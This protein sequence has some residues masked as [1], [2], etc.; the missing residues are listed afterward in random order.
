M[1]PRP[2]RADV[3]R[4]PVLRASL[5][6]LLL[7][8]ITQCAIKHLY[9][10]GKEAQ[11][12]IEYAKSFE[13]R[14]CNHWQTKESDDECISGVMGDENRYKYCVATQSNKLRN[15]LRKVPGVPLLF[16]KRS[17]IL[18]EPP[19]DA[20]VAK[21]QEVSGPCHSCTYRERARRFTCRPVV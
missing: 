11:G 1:C 6:A 4:R 2:R 7:P 9:D 20:S 17:I 5:L 15:Q 14:K 16:E 8:V 19:S 3:A 18:L 21:R 12:A 10:Q 13:R